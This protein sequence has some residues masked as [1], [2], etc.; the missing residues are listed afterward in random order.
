MKN[1]FKTTHLLRVFVATAIL[2]AGMSCNQ[3]KKA[4]LSHE[5]NMEKVAVVKDVNLPEHGNLVEVK[6]TGMNFILPDT[7]PSGWTSFRYA[8]ESP[9]AH[10][11]LIDKLPIVEGKQITYDDFGD[12]PP[13]FMDA[14]DLIN[15]G[16][17]EEGF[18]EFGRLPAWFSE[19]IFSG[20]VGIITP[21]ETAQTT[22]YVEPGT[23]VIEC[24][25]KT[26]GKFHPMSR[27]IIVEES[28]ANEASPAPTLNLAISKEGGIDMKEE[29]VAG[30]Q[31]IAVHYI[32]QS[33]HEHFLG[34]DVHL[35]KLEEGDDLE[36]LNAWMNWAVPS[37]LNTPAPVRFLGGAQEMP[38]GNTAYITVDLKP[39][40]YAWISEVPD[41]ASKGMLKTFSVP[42]KNALTGGSR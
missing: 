9:W 8:N 19:I 16:R 21:G 1:R 10:F 37:G 15:Q 30:L 36:E 41:P 12:I 33:P 31:T 28:T 7:I 38:A 6:T 20:G 40:N 11:M 18:A 2:A 42:S 4:T 24:Y 23:Y 25:V 22:V 34:H 13:I 17:A 5:M 27:Q 39:G 35:V 29:P 26:G 3:K 14:M 32:D